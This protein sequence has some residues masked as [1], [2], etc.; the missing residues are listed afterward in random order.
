MGVPPDKIDAMLPPRTS[1][2]ELFPLAVPIWTVWQ[3]MGTQWRMCDGVVL[4]LDLGVLPL[5]FDQRGVE[6]A[7]QREMWPLLK[8]MERAALDMLQDK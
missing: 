8:E 2:L 7:L 1:C 6:S 5:V 4:G 3:D